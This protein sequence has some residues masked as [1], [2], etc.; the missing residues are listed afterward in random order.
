MLFF[1]RS[2]HIQ[3]YN[4]HNEN[5]I[6]NWGVIEFNNSGKNGDN[7]WS[8]GEGYFFDIKTD[9]IQKIE[10]KAKIELIRIEIVEPET[11]SLPTTGADT[12]I[13]LTEEQIVEPK[14]RSLPT[15]G[16]GTDIELT[17]EQI[18]IFEDFF[19]NPSNH[20]NQELANL[21][22]EV[23]ES[24]SWPILKSS[25]SEDNLKSSP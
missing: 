24:Y 20:N 13:G 7:K 25:G 4:D 14:T 12:D 2:S 17:K 8:L 3:I 11:R 23:S 6:E 21:I 15:M 10:K 5:S 16:V 19:T 22:K 9:A 18:E 1:T